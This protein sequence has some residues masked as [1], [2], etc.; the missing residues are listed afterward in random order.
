MTTDCDD[1]DRLESDDTSDVNV[2]STHGMQYSAPHAPDS[3]S[4]QSK[5]AGFGNVIVE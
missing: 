5:S 1:V 3:P 2:L 4:L